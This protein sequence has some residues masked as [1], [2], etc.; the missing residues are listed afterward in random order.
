[1]YAGN[2]HYI[3]KNKSNKSRTFLLKYIALE[4]K[5]SKNIFIN[6]NLQ[7][8]CKINFVEHFSCCEDGKKANNYTYNIKIS[9]RTSS[10][11][12]DD[13]NSFS[14]ISTN[15]LSLD[16]SFDKSTLTNRSIQVLK[17]YC[18]SLK[19]NKAERKWTYSFFNKKIGIY[20]A[21][22]MDDSFFEALKKRVAIGLRSKSSST[23]SNS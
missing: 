10:D 20:M 18:Y 4:L 11:N 7:S 3:S 14:Q 21:K 5:K 9:K 17:D 13:E 6:S 22:I 15:P 1:M 8:N 19:K 2:I 12:I 23:S 16:A